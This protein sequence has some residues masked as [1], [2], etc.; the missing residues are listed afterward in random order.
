MGRHELEG[1]RWMAVQSEAYD[2][3]SQSLHKGFK[4][5]ILETMVRR[6]ASVVKNEGVREKIVRDLDGSA[7]VDYE[8]RELA[9]AIVTGLSKPLSDADRQR[10]RYQAASHRWD[11]TAERQLDVSR[12]PNT[13]S[14]RKKTDCNEELR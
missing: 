14:N 10:F 9:E 4:L 2:P 3:V 6:N 8:E 12:L 11:Y 13:T 1:G 5:L 7:V